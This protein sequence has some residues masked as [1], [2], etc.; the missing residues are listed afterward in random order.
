[1]PTKLDNVVKIKKDIIHLDAEATA[2]ARRGA[3]LVAWRI[4]N[5]KY[6]IQDDI[7]TGK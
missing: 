6:R 1:M 2:R 7:H 5:S 3:A 4:R